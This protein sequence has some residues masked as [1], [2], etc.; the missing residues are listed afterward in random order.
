MTELIDAL[1][2][3][4]E[5]IR[6]YLLDSGELSYASELEQTSPKVLLLAAASYFESAV[7]RF[8]LEFF[9]SVSDGNELARSFVEKKALERQ[10][11]AMFSW[12]ATNA[13]TFWALFG[14]NFKEYAIALA[15][16]EPELRES[17]AAFM[18][19]GSLR[20]KLVHQNY[21]VFTLEK[22]TE[23]LYEL[24]LK[25]ADFVTRL[26]EI[27]ANYPGPERHA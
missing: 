3:S 23:E 15:K 14:P 10:F 26:P 20:N 21:L 25:G 6:Q 16:D 5:D 24:A 1:Y 17:T 4:H 11:H 13:N 2:R 22:T 8:I 12:N 19:I 27:F 18:E 9:D 7:T